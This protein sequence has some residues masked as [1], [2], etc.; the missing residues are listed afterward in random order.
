MQNNSVKDCLVPNHQ[1]VFRINGIFKNFGDIGTGL[2]K[3]EENEKK[4]SWA[5]ARWIPYPLYIWKPLASEQA[6]HDYTIILCAMA[7][8]FFFFNQT[9]MIPNQVLLVLGSQ[10]HIILLQGCLISAQRASMLIVSVCTALG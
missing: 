3:L 1:F 6:P 8:G 10:S 5:A 2:L 4:I 9:K 7:A